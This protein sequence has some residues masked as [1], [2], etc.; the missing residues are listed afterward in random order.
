M[1]R[2][3]GLVQ[4]GVTRNPLGSLLVSNVVNKINNIVIFLPGVLVLCFFVS[5]LRSSKCV[6]H[7]TFVVSGVVRQVKL[8]NG[9][10]VPLVVK[11]NYGMPTV[12]TAHAVRSQGSELVAVL[13]GPLVSYDTHLP[14]CLIVVNT[15]FPG[16]TDFVLLYVCATNVLLTMVVTHVFDGFLIGK[17]SSPFIVRLPPCH[18]PA[19]GDV[20]HRA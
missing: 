1:S 13:I 11:F 3:N 17:R 10:F 20:V 7:T 19:S 15:F 6:T 12:V 2:L 16:Y 18:V 8:R 4:G 9:S 5:V 14:V